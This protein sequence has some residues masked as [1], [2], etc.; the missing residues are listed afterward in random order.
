MVRA[1]GGKRVG[2][3]V[4]AAVGLAVCAML[5]AVCVGCGDDNGGNPGGNN[6]G[7]G[8]PGGNNPGGGNSYTYTGPTKKIGNQTWMAKNLDRATANSK[9]Y[10]NSPDSCAKYGRLYT[11]DDAKTACPSGWHLPSDAEWTTLENTV[12]SSTA[13]KKLKS[14]SGWNYDGN[15]TDDYG[16]SAL[17][18]GFGYSGGDYFYYAGGFGRWWS[19]TEYNASNAWHRLMGY[20]DGNVDRDYYDKT[21]LFSVRCLQD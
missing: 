4:R 6:G 1:I 2:V 21:D 5:A 14:T 17:P 8:N 9:C 18:G 12:G 3:A 15:G 13:G 19:A 20:S 11:W 10:E 16:F 7:G